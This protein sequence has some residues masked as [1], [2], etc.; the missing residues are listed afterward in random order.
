MKIDG[1]GK[2]VV[3]TIKPGLTDGRD[4][5]PKPT[6]EHGFEIIE[7]TPEL[8]EQRV[9]DEARHWEKRARHAESTKEAERVVPL[10]EQMRTLRKGSKQEIDAMNQ[11]IEAAENAGKVEAA[12]LR[13]EAE[14]KVAEVRA[15]LESKIPR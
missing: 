1:Q 12:R 4:G 3:L 11:M 10:P 15:E 7:W 9:K 13:S 14:A 5:D 2:H 8:V 6:L